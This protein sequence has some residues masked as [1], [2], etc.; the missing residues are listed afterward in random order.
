MSKPA[1]PINH[2]YRYRIDITD[3]GGRRLQRSFFLSAPS[4][5]EFCTLRSAAMADAREIYGPYHRFFSNRLGD[6]DTTNQS[7]GQRNDD[8]DPS[9]GVSAGVALSFPIWVGLT[10]LA[11]CFA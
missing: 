8:L 5:R 7:P 4:Y 3:L 1:F 6:E 11:W 2:S 10:W 9:R